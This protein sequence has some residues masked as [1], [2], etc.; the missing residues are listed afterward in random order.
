MVMVS[1]LAPHP[2]KLVVD[3]KSRKVM[4]FIMIEI[5]RSLFDS[6]ILI[7]SFTFSLL[8]WNPILE[9]KIVRDDAKKTQCRD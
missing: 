8:C 3:S 7:H 2:S 5:S 1:A 4:V 6:L 9:P